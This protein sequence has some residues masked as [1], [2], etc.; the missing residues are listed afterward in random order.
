LFHAA[1]G[2]GDTLRDRTGN[3]V[4]ARVR[5]LAAMDLLH[6]PRAGNL[7]LF[8]PRAPHLFA[9]DRGRALNLFGPAGAG[10]IGA[11]ARAIHLPGSRVLDATRR[12][13]A[14][15]AFLNGLP[16][17]GTDADA[18]GL[19]DRSARGVADIAV[20][21]LG[22]GAIGRAA[23]VAVT[24][25][26][27]RPA[28]RVAAFFVA[29]LVDGPAHLVANI[30]VMRLIHRTAHHARFFA[31]ARLIDGPADFAADIPIA[32][33][34]LRPADRVALVSIAGVVNR[35][36]AGHRDRFTNPVV[37]GLRASV[38]LPLPDDLLNRLITGL[39]AACG[40][41]IVACRCGTRRGTD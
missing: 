15:N 29:G 13:R 3:L 16:L 32:G 36:A 34:V 35:L 11:G 17:A 39:A 2:I 26:I 37:N 7:P 8:D 18:F 14:G 19:A 1:S 20:F 28:H 25:L 31:I 33:L 5:D 27:N 4:A 6:V 21:R 10:L 12:H 23:H 22:A 30:A 40:L 24:G 9:A 41:T 38:I